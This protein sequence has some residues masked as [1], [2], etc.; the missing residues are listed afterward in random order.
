MIEL[1]PIPVYCFTFNKH[2]TISPNK[3]YVAYVTHDRRISIINLKDKD[4]FNISQTDFYYG[5]F[6]IFK[7]I[8]IYQIAFNNNSDKL[9]CLAQK[10]K[11][12]NLYQFNLDNKQSLPSRQWYKHSKT[13]LPADAKSF[14]VNETTQEINFVSFQKNKIYYRVLQPDTQELIHKNIEPVHSDIAK[15]KLNPINMQ[16]NVLSVNNELNIFTETNNGWQIKHQVNN[17][18]DIPAS[19]QD[20]NILVLKQANKITIRSALAPNYG[21]VIYTTVYRFPIMDFSINSMGNKIEVFFQQNSDSE[22][23]RSTLYTEDDP[24]LWLKKDHAIPFQISVPNNNLHNYTPDEI[25]SMFTDENKLIVLF[26]TLIIMV[27]FNLKCQNQ[28]VQIIDEKTLAARQRHYESLSLQN[29]SIEAQYFKYSTS[30]ISTAHSAYNSFYPTYYDATYD[31]SGNSGGYD[32]GNYSY[33]DA[34]GC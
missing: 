32:G 29:D 26:D 19:S 23:N 22:I 21:K 31:Y 10:G 13:L 33:G 4:T 8:K 3:H 11:H 5:I 30:S 25:T 12:A 7:S 17:C 6:H 14:T 27:R 9:Y 28:D 24:R 1:K 15:I 18:D 34:S 2:K 20:G 16:L